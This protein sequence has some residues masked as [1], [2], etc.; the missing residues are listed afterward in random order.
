MIPGAVL[1][2]RELA[3]EICERLAEGESLKEI[4]RS[5]HMPSSTAV[6]KWALEDRDGFSSRYARARDLQL[7]SWSDDIVEISDDGANDWMERNQ[8]DNPGWQLNGEHVQ[9]SRL[10]S[11]NRKWLLS[12]LKPEKYGDRTA[13][14]GANG[15]DLIPDPSATDARILALLMKAGMTEDQA[16][17][18]L[19]AEPV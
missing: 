10:R 7:E 13:I 3:D 11:D 2:T 16:R 6:R 18:A 15:K 9:R 8:P 5:P 19:D 14:T 17:A 4:C 1:Y 12:K